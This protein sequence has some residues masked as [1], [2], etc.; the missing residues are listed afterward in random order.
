M[1]N[2]LFLLDDHNDLLIDFVQLEFIL[3]LNIIHLF[4]KDYLNI[5]IIIPNYLILR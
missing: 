2:Q 5:F 3:N 1:V 4:H